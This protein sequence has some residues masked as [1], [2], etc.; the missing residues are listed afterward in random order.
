MFEA[1]IAVSLTSQ[2]VRNLSTAK[3]KRRVFR[4]Q[5]DCI[6]KSRKV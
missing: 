2:G 1:G 6:I 5:C 3:G 4:G